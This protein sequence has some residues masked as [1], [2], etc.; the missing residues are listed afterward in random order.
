MPVN[1][2]PLEIVFVI[3]EIVITPF[4][5]ALKIPQYK[6]RQE[7]GTLQ[8]PRNFIFSRNEEGISS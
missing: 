5:S 7:S 4:S 8:H 2:R 1:S 3:H 6:F